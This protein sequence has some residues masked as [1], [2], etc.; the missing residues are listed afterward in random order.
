MVDFTVHINYNAL[1]DFI[2]LKLR[3][4]AK[5]IL[6]ISRALQFHIEDAEDLEMFLLCTVKFNSLISDFLDRIV[7]PE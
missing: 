3:E 2:R 5:G 1:D 7:R 6:C 4:G